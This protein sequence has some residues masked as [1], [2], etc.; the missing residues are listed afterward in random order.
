VGHI[1]WRTGFGV[2]PFLTVF[3]GFFQILS[4]A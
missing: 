3:L 2:K 1:L 4:K